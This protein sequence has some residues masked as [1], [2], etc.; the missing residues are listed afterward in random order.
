MVSQLS[1]PYAGLIELATDIIAKPAQI[2]RQL[3]PPTRKYARLNL[4]PMLVVEQ[5]LSSSRKPFQRAAQM[6][7][8]NQHKTTSNLKGTTSRTAWLHFNQLL[9]GHTR[10][11]A[12]MHRYGI[13]TSPVCD[14]GAPLQTPELMIKCCLGRF[15]EGGLHRI[16]SLDDDAIVWL[17]GLN[18]DV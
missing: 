17:G 13:V 2:Y 5:R 14:C 8:A 6:L 18:V 16:V 1:H 11:A 12:D 3:Q 15:L 4:A 10:L 7:L 9:S